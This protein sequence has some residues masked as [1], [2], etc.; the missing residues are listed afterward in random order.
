MG[1]PPIF[2][3]LSRKTQWS[4]MPQAEKAQVE[5]L[6]GNYVDI[7][8]HI[9]PGLD[10]GAVNPE[11]ALAMLRREAEEGVGAVILTPHQMPG[12]RNAAKEGMEKRIA[13]LEEGIRKENI[14]VRIYP[15]AELFYR[16]GMGK[17]LEKGQLC[18]LARSHYV[19]VEFM[20]G[21]SW[22]YIRDGVYELTDGYWPVLAHI[23]RY[24]QV[25]PR[26]DR[27]R[28]LIEM[29]ACIQMNAGSIT[30]EQG[31]AVK[32]TC[33]KL[34]GQQLVHFIGTDAH[35]ADGRRAP[36]MEKCAALLKKKVGSRYAE[37][38][39]RGNAEKILSNTRL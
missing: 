19:L 9:M 3:L 37:E 29:G 14:P 32:R 28:E 18:T 1:R 5:R 33:M 24:Q 20:P 25:A 15:G 22:E 30:G 27:V 17:L 21:E 6:P 7:H 34:L 26:T 2:P 36:R 16:H 11:M 12:H 8:C 23:E 4:E 39:L 38:L 31:I 13:L 10:D 35:R